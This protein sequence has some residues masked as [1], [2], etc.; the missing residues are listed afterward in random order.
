MNG[1]SFFANEWMKGPSKVG[2]EGKS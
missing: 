1:D 2:N